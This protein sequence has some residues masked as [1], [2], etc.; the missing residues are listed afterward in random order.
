M[1]II[2]RPSSITSKIHPDTPELWPLNCSKLGFPLSKYQYLKHW[3]CVS[4]RKSL[5]IFSQNDS[6][7]H[8]VLQFKEDFRSWLIE[9]TVQGGRLDLLTDGQQVDLL[10]FIKQS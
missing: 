8:E 1:D 7:V 3:V 5:Y 10:S 2:S 6:M 4:G 9:E